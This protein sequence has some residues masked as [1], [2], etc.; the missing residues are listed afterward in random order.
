MDV[1]MLRQAFVIAYDAESARREKLPLPK[2]S[3]HYR[4]KIISFTEKYKNKYIKI[5]SAYVKRGAVIAATA[6]LA[7]SMS[8]SVEAV[9]QRVVSFFIEV[10]R[11]ESH[12]NFK[13]D[14][15]VYSNYANTSYSKTVDRGTYREKATFYEYTASG[16]YETA[17]A[18]SSEVTY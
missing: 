6:I 12:V 18:Y 5:S 10:F 3:E 11:E 17:T 15:T 9:R 4:D 13:N 7:F 14:E 2:L 1:E 8:M 16:S